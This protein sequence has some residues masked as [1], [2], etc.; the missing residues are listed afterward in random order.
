[1]TDQQQHLQQVLEQQRTLVNEINELNSQ[2]ENKRS[3]AIKLQGVREYLEQLGVELP[4]EDEAAETAD[5]PPPA[6]ET[7]VVED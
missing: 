1:M 2:V 7:E 5:E 3:L 6:S 4:K